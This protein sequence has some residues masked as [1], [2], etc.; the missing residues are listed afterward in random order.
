MLAALAVTIALSAGSRV[1][2]VQSASGWQLLRNGQ[3]YFIKGVG[4]TGRM[5]DLIR[6]GGNSMR[7]WGADKAGEELDAMH[8]RGLTYTVGI[9]LGHKSYF[10]YGNPKQVAEQKEMV[11]QVVLKHRNHPA[12]LI[13]GLGNEMEINNDTPQLWTAIED[14]AKM[15]KTLDPNHPTMTV[16]AEISNEKIANIKR[17]APSIDILGVNSYGGLP[18]L[19]K[20]LKE[21]GWDKPYIITEFGPLGPWERPKTP[22]GAALEQP[23]NEKAAFYAENYRASVAGQPGWCLGSYAF[24]WGDKQEETP[25]WFGM[26]LPNG[27]KTA[28]V[29]VISHAWTGKWPT[30]RA[31][32]IQALRFAQSGQAVNGGDPVAAEVRASDP[33]GDPLTY[34][35]ELKREVMDKR[36]AGEGEQRPEV[37][38]GFVDGKTTPRIS[39]TLPR[40]PGAYRLY[41]YVSDGKG[42]GASANAPFRIVR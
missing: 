11:R 26:F 41:I 3:P 17:Y 4:G 9:W 32:E 5:D 2:V 16:V 28:A 24:L 38:K 23:S 34:R 42:A 27:E 21:A 33:N 6:Y 22:W 36:Y 12:L 13:W 1:Q 35:W 29:D 37:L 8:A 39:F 31:P 30:Q 25:T 40:E 14:L 7:G 10:D 15:V 20:R 19:P 18:T